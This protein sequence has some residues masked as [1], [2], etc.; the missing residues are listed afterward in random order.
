MAIQEQV[1]NPTSFNYQYSLAFVVVVDHHRGHHRG[2]GDPGGHRAS[3]S[4]STLL[5]TYAPLQ[6]SNL[7]FVL[8][9]FGALTYASHPEG[10][11]EFQKRTWTLRFQRWI[12]RQDGSAQPPTAMLAIAGGRGPGAMVNAEIVEARKR[13]GQSRG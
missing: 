3:P 1:A 11:L 6:L 9:A 7:T 13:P 2:G 10:V 4:S 5:G 12:F 8:F